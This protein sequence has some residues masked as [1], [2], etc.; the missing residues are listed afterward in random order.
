MLDKVQTELLEVLLRAEAAGRQKEGELEVDEAAAVSMCDNP[1]EEGGG[2]V[3]A[4]LWI[5]I[6]D[7]MRERLSA[8]P[9]CGN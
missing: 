8:K 5:P 9:T 6:T 2:Y 7:S 4:W 3:Q 1:L